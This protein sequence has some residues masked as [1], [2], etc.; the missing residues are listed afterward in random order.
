MSNEWNNLSESYKPNKAKN[1]ASVKLKK[2]SII[3]K[4]IVIKKHQNP[5][6]DAESKPIEVKNEF[7]LLSQYH[8][9]PRSLSFSYN[10][11]CEKYLTWLHKSNKNQILNK[12]N[13]RETSLEVNTLTGRPDLNS[14]L[15]NSRINLGHKLIDLDKQKTL[16]S[17][18]IE[19]LK[20]TH[21][22]GLFKYFFNNIEN[23]FHIVVFGIKAPISECCKVN[24]VVQVSKDYGGRIL[25]PHR[26]CVIQCISNFCIS[27]IER[28]SLWPS[29][30]NESF[31][32]NKEKTD[33]ILKEHSRDFQDFNNFSG[34]AS[35]ST[36]SVPNNK[37]FPFADPLQQLLR[38]HKKLSY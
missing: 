2:R 35:I 32:G 9:N 31:I 1:M 8:N 24:L 33:K 12:S 37:K 5:E 4:H 3:Y 23:I 30:E 15:M 28:D 20:V 26:N 10:R 38:H 14:F 17:L 16:K 7:P 13:Y 29:L 19:N 11:N 34:I 6:Q 25:C 36:L 27:K 21:K 22:D 18:T